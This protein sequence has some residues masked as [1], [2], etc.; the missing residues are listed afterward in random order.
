M[1]DAIS[2]RSPGRRVA[3]STSRAVL[4]VPAR[5]LP[6]WRPRLQARMR[7]DPLDHCRFEDGRDDL[8]LPAAVRAV[9]QVN[10]EDP[11]YSPLTHQSET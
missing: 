5:R 8:D 11:F 3:R 2:H 10:V 6:G 7:E 1:P 4:Y 9:F